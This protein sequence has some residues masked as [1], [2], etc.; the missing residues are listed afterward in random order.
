M[1]VDFVFVFSARHSKQAFSALA[2]RKRLY[3]HECLYNHRIACLTVNQN[4]QL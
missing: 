3:E 2:Y 4:I 1:N